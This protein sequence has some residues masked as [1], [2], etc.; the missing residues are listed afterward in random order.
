MRFLNKFCI[1]FILVTSATT[2][3]AAVVFSEI[4]YDLKEGSDTGREWVE[5][6][7]MGSESV[8]LT[9][10]KLYEANTNHAIT[11]LQ[12]SETIP[13]GGFAI[14]AN[15]STKFLTDHVGFSGTIFDSSF[16]LLNSGESLSIHDANLADIDG[17]IYT[18]TQG[19]AGDG[20]SLQKVG[21]VWQGGTPTPG[22]PNTLTSASTENG[23][24]Q[25]ETS[26]TSTGSGSTN[27]TVA[28]SSSFSVEPQIFASAGEK[29]RMAVVGGTVTFSGRVWGLKKEPIENARM[30]WN[31]GDGNTAEGKTVAHAYRYPGTYIVTIDASSGYYSASDRVTVEAVSADVVISSVGDSQSLFIELHNKSQYEL[32]L[33]FWSIRAGNLTFVIPEHTFITAGAKIKFGSEV[34]G[35]TSNALA[36]VALYYPN[37]ILAHPYSPAAPSNIS[38][39]PKNN[40][41]TIVASKTVKLPV[42]PA[43]TGSTLNDS[44]SMTNTVLS[45]NIVAEKKLPE[46]N[47]QTA[48]L[49]NIY[50]ETHSLFWWI[51]GVCALAV[52]GI[53][54]AFFT[55][56][57]P[58]LELAKNEADAYEII[59]ETEDDKIP[60]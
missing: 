14:I 21:S 8:N 6:T 42:L 55:K 59:E 53:A 48:S 57:N 39:A 36:S 24:S 43:P 56:R 38:V 47:T 33:S 10:W 25:Q 28:A 15:D 18:S 54:S 19:G 40:T 26:T 9:G 35:V 1:F 41:K 3:S 12:G 52:V 49:D 11:L 5:I 2:A 17:V 16:S 20:N 60:F 44:R 7:N 4:M 46:E 32:D 30:L 27:T 22:A 51:M 13:V 34:T 37:G 29:K 58:S 31:F 23:T 45:Q 50:P